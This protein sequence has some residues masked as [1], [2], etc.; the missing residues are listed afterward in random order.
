M[1][2]DKPFG[3]STGADAVVAG[4]DLSART[5][6]VTGANTGIGEAT[7]RVLAGAGARVIYACRNR[8]SGEAAVARAQTQYPN[9][10]AE[11]AELDLASFASINRFAAALPDQ[12]IDALICNAGLSLLSY[13]ETE[14]QFERVVGVSHIGHFLLAR[15]LMP[16]LLAAGTSRVVMVSSLSH[17]SPPKL[18]FAALPMTKDNF[19]GMTAYGQAKLCNILMAK[20]LQQRYGDQ[21][22]TAC[23]LHPGTLV[24]TDIG[25]NS[26]LIGMLMKLVSPFTKSPLQGAATS[27]YAVV[28]EPEM[29]L[30]GKYLKDCHVE[31]CSAEA[32]D[33]AVA[34][35]LWDLSNVWVARTGEPP[36]WP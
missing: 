31:P 2:A 35:R 19:N 21:G 29:E 36:A 4:H 12:T 30:A 28:H 7:A 22:L 33:P 23:S 10:N 25:R 9:C 3:S 16:R 18:N 15:L 5:I 8:D 32:N 27:V 20:S 24:T 17:G 13:A 34:Q 11:F 1:P 26:K 6:V 14:E